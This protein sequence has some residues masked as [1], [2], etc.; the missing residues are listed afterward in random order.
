MCVLSPSFP[1]HSLPVYKCDLVLH[2]P[3]RMISDV[4]TK[5]QIYNPSVRRDLLGLFNLVSSLRTQSVTRGVFGE[6]VHR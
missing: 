2:L 5:N 6:S 3:L 1:A 4:E